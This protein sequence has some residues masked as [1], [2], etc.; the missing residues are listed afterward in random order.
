MYFAP[1]LKTPNVEFSVSFWT[2]WYMQYKE[3]ASGSRAIINLSAEIPTYWNFIINFSITIKSSCIKHLKLKKWNQ[4]QPFLL[5]LSWIALTNRSKW[6]APSKPTLYQIVLCQLTAFCKWS[7]CGVLRSQLQKKILSLLPFSFL[8]HL[9]EV[10]LSSISLKKNKEETLKRVYDLSLFKLLF[11]FR[12]RR[13]YPKLQGINCS[14]RPN[15][16][17]KTTSLNFN[18]NFI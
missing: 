15:S 14:S 11:R 18:P 4:R 13:F 2:G 10:F 8:C 17:G 1:D 7:T 12:S 5:L 16:S 9:Q 6:L 3:A